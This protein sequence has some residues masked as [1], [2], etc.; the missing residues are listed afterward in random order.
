MTTLLWTSTKRSPLAGH[1]LSHSQGKHY[2]CTNGSERERKTDGEELA[3]HAA[4]E[5]ELFKLGDASSAFFTSQYMSWGNDLPQGAERLRCRSWAHFRS[6]QKDWPNDVSTFPVPSC[7]SY[8]IQVVPI[9]GLTRLTKAG[10]DG[11]LK[12]SNLNWSD[13]IR[14]LSNVTRCHKSRNDSICEAF[15]VRPVPGL[16]KMASWSTDRHGSSRTALLIFADFERQRLACAPSSPE[17]S[18]N[19]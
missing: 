6:L 17:T 13:L 12:D 15:Y 9:S 2:P 19:S 8:W 14:L 7:S 3:L 4:G 10:P 18:Q 16:Q 11:C 1:S 5:W